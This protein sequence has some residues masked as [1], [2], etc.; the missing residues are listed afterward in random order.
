MQ[1]RVI[2][3]V[4]GIAGTLLWFMPLA[5]VE[6]MGSTSYQTGASVGGMAYLL[7]VA[8]ITY[9]IFSW[10]DRFVLRIITACTAL[11][12]AVI[13][14]LQAG[15]TTAWGLL[16]LLLVSAASVGFAVKDYRSEEELEPR[17]G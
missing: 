1:S 17:A 5:K 7:L 16:L 8:S 6:F 3:L 14:V 2:G 13:F 11:L 15:A 4:L 12:I 10:R 9:G